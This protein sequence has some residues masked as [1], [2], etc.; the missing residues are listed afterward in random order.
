MS[1]IVRLAQIRG[2][3]FD[4]EEEAGLTEISGLE[5][6]V[7]LACADLINTNELARTKDI[8]SHR[9]LKGFS[10]PSV[11]RALKSLVNQ[12]L[13]SHGKGLRGSYRLI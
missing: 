9:F 6:E 13:L 10:R 3:M 2:L 11:F 8:L 12:N 4:I 5:R 1:A 7:L